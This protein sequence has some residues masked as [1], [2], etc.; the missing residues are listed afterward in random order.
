[1][2]IRLIPPVPEPAILF[3][4]SFPN[5]PANIELPFSWRYQIDRLA[6]SDLE[7]PVDIHALDKAAGIPTLIDEVSFHI[8]SA[9]VTC[10]FL[11]GSREEW[12][13]LSVACMEALQRVMNDVNESGLV[14]ERERR[15][16]QDQPRIGEEAALPV[17]VSTPV[18]ASRHKKQRSLLMTLVAYVSSISSS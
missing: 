12:P 4:I 8:S 10:R 14:S 16:D 1:M 7:L 18:K 15:K 17:P 3:S 6:V 5:L 13:L 11:D 2:L 9:T